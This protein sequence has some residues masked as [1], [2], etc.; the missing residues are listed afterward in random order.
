MSDRNLSAV[1]FRFTPGE[2][3][4]TPHRVSAHDDSGREIGHMEWHM[5]TGRVLGIEVDE[6][7]RRQ[8]V[9][10]GM[11]FAGQ[12]AAADKRSVVKPKHSQERTDAGD[13]WAKTVGGTIPRRTHFDG[14]AL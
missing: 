5:K 7:H 11:W 6:S 14:R 8:G 12:R 1:Q 9:A 4:V 3:F 10:T 13:A 2:R